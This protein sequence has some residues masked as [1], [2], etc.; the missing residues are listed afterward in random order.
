MNDCTGWAITD[1]YGATGATGTIKD[2]GQQ[3]AIHVTASSVTAGP[4]NLTLAVGD[5]LPA[6]GR[7]DRHDDPD[8]HRAGVHLLRHRRSPHQGCDVNDDPLGRGEG[9][10]VRRGGGML[11]KQAELLCHAYKRTI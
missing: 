4:G 11:I 10:I 7:D 9:R 1:Y 3:E 2:S 8:Q 5:E 6:S